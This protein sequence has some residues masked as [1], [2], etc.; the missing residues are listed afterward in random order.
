M[1]KIFSIVA[2]AMILL[3]NNSFAAKFEMKATFAVTRCEKA[4]EYVCSGHHESRV[5]VAAVDIPPP[6]ESGYGRW[7][8][9][10]ELDGLKFEYKLDV[11]N[12]DLEPESILIARM[13]VS[14][15]AGILELTRFATHLDASK[16]HQ[17][18]LLDGGVFRK[19]RKTYLVS[20]KLE[21]VQ[22]SK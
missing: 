21:S 13:G 16:P 5:E 11:A 17:I 12:P 8:R 20:L 4:D 18:I 2:L 1:K 9:A 19:T 10:I 14:H 3:P 7:N 22:D 15:A 6:Y